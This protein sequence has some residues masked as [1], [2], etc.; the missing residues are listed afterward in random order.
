MALIIY[1]TVGYDSYVS[2][3]EADAI[4][5]DLTMHSTS[6]EALSTEDRE[7]YLRIAMRTMEDGIDQTVN[8]LPLVGESLYSCMKESQAL[9]A[10]QDVVNN[11]SAGGVTQTTGAVK[12]EKAG[13]VEVQYYDVSGGSSSSAPYP[14]P[15]IAFSCL[16]A[17]GFTFPSTGGFKQSTL[18]RS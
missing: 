7:R 15:K 13:A 14:I 2:V 5:S 3:V 1:P 17:M 9:I 10:L 4:I 6:W 16:S 18:G 11:I 8:P 12:K